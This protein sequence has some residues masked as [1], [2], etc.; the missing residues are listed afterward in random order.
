MT[1]K[2]YK[3]CVFFNT[4]KNHNILWY[5]DGRFYFGEWNVNLMG[6]G[7]KSG[8]GFEYLPGKY[9]YRGQF[10]EGKRKG[11]GTMKILNKEKPVIYE[12]EWD[13]GN[14]NGKGKQID[15]Y[16]ILYEGQ[17]KDGKKN[18]IGKLKLPDGDIYEGEF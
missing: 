6:E 11:F 1:V 5:F 17:W 4:E 2:K 16:D 8:W 9:Y 13:D 15:E 18:G 3:N 14:K 12:G 10:F 7:Q